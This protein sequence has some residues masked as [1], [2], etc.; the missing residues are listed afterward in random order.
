VAEQERLYRTALDESSNTFNLA[1]EIE[2]LFS[3]PDGIC[4]DGILHK[5]ATAEEVTQRGYQV[6]EGANADE[7]LVVSR[8][9]ALMVSFMDGLMSGED[10]YRDD[11]AIVTTA[12]EWAA[13]AQYPRPAKG[14]R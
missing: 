5:Q 13:R 8:R 12:A 1:M 11:H 14:A 3:G 6:P 10:M 7:P 9:M 2:R 4:M